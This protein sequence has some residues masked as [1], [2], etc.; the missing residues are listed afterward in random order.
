MDIRVT[1]A[2]LWYIDS[3]PNDESEF[4]KH[5]DFDKNHQ[6]WE[7]SVLTD[8]D[9]L[10]VIH[11]EI[12]HAM[13][14]HFKGAAGEFNPNFTALMDPQPGSFDVTKRCSPRRRC[15]KALSKGRPFQCSAMRTR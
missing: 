3:N 8:F 10:S 14:W 15:T 1:D 2:I 12:G 9:L 5:S 13:G 11:Q 4:S 7:S 6:H